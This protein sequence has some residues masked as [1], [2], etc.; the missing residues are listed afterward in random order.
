M[1]NTHIHF[2]TTE[3]IMG[4]SRRAGICAVNIKTR[5][6]WEKWS[7]SVDC[8]GGMGNVKTH[9]ANYFYN[10]AKQLQLIISPAILWR[11]VRRSII[12]CGFGFLCL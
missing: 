6:V 9:T 10:G 2:G 4:E 1:T 12:F 8:D 7:L 3:L 5:V 11:S